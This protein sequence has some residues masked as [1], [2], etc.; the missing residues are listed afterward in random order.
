MHGIV[1][2]QPINQFEQVV[3]GGGSGKLVQPACQTGF[4]AG[5]TL[6]FDIHLTG[7]IIAHQNG[8]QLRDWHNPNG[9]DAKDFT[10][11][12]FYQKGLGVRDNTGRTFWFDE[13]WIE[14]CPY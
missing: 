8:G 3:L 11:W 7:W 1:G 2:I 14:H 13:R 6:V 10:D 12:V 5:L 4:G 9:G